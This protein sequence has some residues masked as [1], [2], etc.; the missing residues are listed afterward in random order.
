MNIFRILIINVGLMTK[1]HPH[2][3]RM[4]AS[5]PFR[6]I[7]ITNSNLVTEYKRAFGEND[8]ELFELRR[9]AN[10]WDKLKDIA[11]RTRGHPMS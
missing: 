9:P 7:N 5:G 11:D 1:Q 6:A 4:V 3:W 10:S 2:L 8:V